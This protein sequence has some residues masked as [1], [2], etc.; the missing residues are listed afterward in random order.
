PVS[1]SLGTL[2]DRSRPGRIAAVMTFVPP[3]GKIAKTIARRVVALVA[4][5]SLTSVAADDA[6][7]ASIEAGDLSSLAILIDRGADLNETDVDGA[8]AL[9]WAVYADRLDAARLL[10]EAGVDATLASR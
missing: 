9:H 4:A 10:V 8:T 6:L 2:L 5:L 1:G 7:R 3:N